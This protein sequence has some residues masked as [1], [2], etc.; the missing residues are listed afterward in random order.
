MRPSLLI[1]I[2]LLLPACKQKPDD[3]AGTIDIIV[4]ADNDGYSFDSDCDD[5]DPDVNPAAD[6][7]CDGIDNNCDTQIDEGLP[8]T[9]WYTDGDGDGYGSD[10]SALE[11]CAAPDGYIA[12]G[13]D[14]D[15]ADAA[16]HPNADED[17]CT[18]PNDY[19]CDG[20]VGAVDNDGD[21]YFACEECDDGNVAVNPT[22]AEVCNDLDDNCDGVTDTDAVDAATWYYDTDGDGYGDDGS[23]ITTCDQP[24]GAVE[25]GGD[26]DDG[27]TAY[28][29]GAS[30]S[31]NEDIDYNCD[32]SSGFE[33]ADADGTAACD[34][35]DD[36]DPTAYPGG[37]EV[38]DGIDN[39]CDG[40]ADDGATDALIWY[41]DTDG[42]GYGDPAVTVAA[43]EA[44]AGYVAT[45]D[46]CNDADLAYNPAAAES[47][48]DPA[49]YNCDGSTG[50]ADDDGDGVAACD[51]CDDTNAAAG[52]GL[53][54][55]CDGDDNNCD[56]TVDEATATGAPTWYADVDGDGYGDEGAT[57]IACAQP[58]SFVATP[59]DCDDA[60]GAYNPAAAEAC[61]DTVDYNCDGSVAY[62]DDDADG[63]AACEECD[64]SDGAVSPAA[65]EICDG[66]DN[67]CDG[68]VDEPGATGEST[69]YFDAD[70]DGYG[71]D[72]TS[73]VA[74]DAPDDAYVTIPGD[75]DD[76]SP[77]YNPGAEEACT[78][79]VDYN[80]DGS[81]AFDDTDGD[82]YAAC[83]ECD[84][85]DGA[86]NPGAVESCD[87]VDND[88]DGNVDE[89][90][91]TGETTWYP[92]GDSDSYG[93]AAG[94][95]V[96]CDAPIGFV[97]DGTDC[98]DTTGAAYP[99][100]EEVCDYRDNDC[101]GGVDVDATDALTYYADD[102]GDTYGDAA[103]PVDA[104][105]QPVGSVAD[106]DDCDDT[107]AAINPAATE[108]CDGADED[109]DGL[110]DDNAVDATSW[111]EDADEDGYGDP[112]TSVDA[113]DMPAGYVADATDCDPVDG[114]NN[115]DALEQC[116]AVDNDCDGDT[117]EEAVDSTT[118]YADADEDGYGDTSLY[119]EACDAPEGYLADY[120]DCDDSVSTV[121]PGGTEVCNGLDDDCSG[122]IDDGATDALTYYVDA[123]EDGYGSSSS[124]VDACDAPDGYVAS[125][126]D[127]NDGDDTIRPGASELCN[128][129]DDD[130]DGFTDESAIDRDTWYAD[131]DGD[132]YGTSTSTLACDMPSGYS[133]DDGDCDDAEV[134]ANPGLAEVCNDALDNDCDGTDNACSIS[135][136]ITA[137]T[138]DWTLSGAASNDYLGS[139]TALG[140][141]NN[142]GYDDS[143]I[144][145]YGWDSAG[146]GSRTD[147]RV[148]IHHAALG[149]DTTATS[150][151]VVSSTQSNAYLGQSLAYLG[152]TNGDGY[153]D[154]ALGAY[155]YDGAATDGG[156]VFV[157]TTPRSGSVNDTSADTTVRG[158]AASDWAGCSVTGA[159][160]VND[161]GYMD[162]LI[163]ANQVN[164][165][166]YTDAGAVGLFYGPFTSGNVAMN[167][168]GSYFVG[169][170]NNEN[171]GIAMAGQG[172]YDGD[173]Y[174]DV[175]FGAHLSDS[176]G[177]DAGSVY[178][179]YGPT[180]S[181]TVN[182]TSADV[183]INGAAA[184]DQFGRSVAW[185]DTDGDGADDLVVG[186]DYTDNGAA[187]NAGTAYVFASGTGSGSAST[188]T[189][190]FT[191]VTG[192]DYVGRSITNGGD[193][194][195][196]AYAD[197]VVGATGY[198]NGA[199]SGVGAAYLLYGPFT[200]AQALSTYDARIRGSASA[201]A[202]GYT[203][204]GDGDVNADGFAD[205]VV[206][207]IAADATS[208]SNNGAGYVFYGGGY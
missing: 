66:I 47:C 76:T 5:A 113:C 54:E 183:R 173:G 56:G 53:D 128:D 175:A 38:C 33:D 154:Y 194:N 49:D 107:D 180:T 79:T 110:V 17:D 15:D 125:S 135:G 170:E 22:Q 45:G 146:S 164:V 14:C 198:D 65:S 204:S 89:P 84:D 138:A 25:V 46:D 1:T 90:G 31:C 189:A 185:A 23:A 137:A 112:D 147:G 35:C 97:S 205:F 52:P 109:C 155:R 140:D 167:A 123:D 139:A 172:D 108:T 4:D 201:D 197:I 50:Y 48:S 27:D 37:T 40:T 62:A 99:G 119:V 70:G 69:W 144:G 178:V 57:T 26:C 94:A 145:A 72:G 8:S 149:T 184:G 134:D 106:A 165:G 114:G 91:A 78:D 81:I 34:D 177:A 92:D 2:A 85:G 20:A 118:W 200:G 208:L 196:D 42:D 61:T 83:E 29:P 19:N 176:N 124:T 44:P 43:C 16:Y 143:L 133:A 130:C 63:F 74:C 122:D 6:E 191:G 101:D 104:C 188:A 64:D 163:S 11:A 12:E 115:P 161:D 82:G 132:G 3:S 141:V 179:F 86:V 60:D 195:G 10:A 71:D 206:G 68:T 159:G 98:D 30:E 157:F 207:S 151:V 24:S 67:N 193:V 120:T 202:V 103:S 58:D 77:L 192:S 166:A 75:C 199:T 131:A 51:D 186:A 150:D 117:D 111:Y 73:V 88:C 96:A 18:D 203:V 174:S 105:T 121:N 41:A 169:G 13:G 95:Y 39:D 156:A 36:A 7:L 127:C 148:Y 142:D 168:G 171:I 55:I 9:P 87:L 21:G 158:V 187:V 162:M 93:D 100:A 116:D 160:D 190:S 129:T 152:D 182:A 136:A 181:G 28:N 80:C 102:D 153:C 32:G 59:G 126:T